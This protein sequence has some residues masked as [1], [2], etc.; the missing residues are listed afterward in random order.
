M[1][2]IKCRFCN[3]S[4]KVC[5]IDLFTSPPSNSYLLKNE[6]NYPE[7][8][9]PLK[10]Y[11]CNYCYLVQTIDHVEKEIMFNESYSYFSSTSDFFLQH[12][13]NFVEK[14]TKELK[15]N[16]GSLVYEVASNDGYL[17]KNFVKKKIN[18]VGIEPTRSTAEYSKRFGFKVEQK[19]L[20]KKFS[21]IL[22]IKY[23]KADLLIGNNVLA[24]V[25]NINDFVFAVKNLLKK[26]GT[27]VFEFPHLFNLLK[28][29]QFDTI[30]HEH[31]SYLSAIFLRKLCKKI[32]LKIYKIEKINTHGGSLRTYLTHEN[33]NIKID[34]SVGNIIKEEKRNRLDNKKTYMMF[35]NSIRNIKV[36]F[37][38]YLINK[39]KE[40][41]KIYAYG[42]AA[43]GNTLINYFG[44]K[45]DLIEGV[46][47]K[48][49]SKQ[50]KF[51]PGSRIPI[52]DPI[53]IKQ[54]KPDLIIIFPW[55]IEIEIKKFI[56]RL[57][58]KTSV[59]S[60]K[61]FIK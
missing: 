48:A 58:I 3:S 55:N 53:K 29:K 7:K 28:F 54:I 36:N 31:Y 60:I 42:A 14:I 20:T 39:K 45:S 41:K 49:K 43:K 59:I 61:N 23:G 26:N 9:Y 51:L 15:L 46:F 25:P 56:K 57:K 13:K 2:K 11:F 19:F 33:S 4:L 32:K 34:N 50:G 6:L 5:V 52:L 8:Y 22:N 10:I 40:K 18:C 24:H 21:N 30:Y 1:K 17:L 35:Q 16:Q 12:A 27:A 38:N 44:I 37:L 47:D